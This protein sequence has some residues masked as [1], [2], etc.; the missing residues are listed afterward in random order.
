MHLETSTVKVVTD[1]VDKT[2]NTQMI[3]NSTSRYSSHLPEVVPIHGMGGMD[4]TQSFE[5]SHTGYTGYFPDDLPMRLGTPPA[6]SAPWKERMRGFWTFSLPLYSIIH[7][8]DGAARVRHIAMITIFLLP[9][10][11]DK[12]VNTVVVVC[13]IHFI[14]SW[15]PDR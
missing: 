4:K 9:T 13:Y 14:H 1:K 12:H 11:G 6:P 3:D 7:M 5:E 2:I 15:L 10:A 8:L